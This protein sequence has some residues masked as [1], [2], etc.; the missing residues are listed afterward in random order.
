[1]GP[2]SGGWGWLKTAVVLVSIAYITFI[3]LATEKRHMWGDD[4]G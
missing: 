3:L 2:G 1:M 4:L